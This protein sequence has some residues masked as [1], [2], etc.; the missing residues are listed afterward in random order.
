MAAPV[1]SI[2]S[3]SSY[4]SVGSHS[5]AD[6]LVA[7][8]VGA[9]IVILP[10]RVLDLVDYSSSSDSNP[11]EDSLLV[12]PEL[13]LV[14]SFLCSN[15]SEADNSSSD[16]SLD[17]SSGSSSDSFS[18]LSLVHSLGCDASGQSHSGPSTRVA[19]PRSLDLSL[20][21]AGPSR[22]RCR[23]PATLVPSST[24]ISR[25][26]APAL[27]D[28]PPRKR[29][30]DSYSSKVGEEEHMEIGTADL[31]TVTDLG[32]SDGVGAHIKDG[33]DIGVE[34]VTSD[35]RGDEQ[36]F[37][38]EASAR[39][40]MEI[41]VDPLATGGISN[42]TGG[43]APDLEGTLYDI[44]HYMYEVPLDRITGTMTNTCSG[45]TS[46]VIEEMINR[47][48]TEALETREA[49][50]NIGL[51]NG[52]DEGG[53]GNGNGNENRGRNGNGNHNEND[54]DARPVV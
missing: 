5:P 38:A 30:R 15:D 1:I 9:V 50:K 48:V 13:P 8:E 40:T 4:E 20:P 39:G 28:L 41:V 12:A 17:I 34:V 16:S 27:T 33:I 3:D 29:F 37:E 51:W 11:S 45:M 47:R 25:S 18:D 10:T 35:I 14:S 36:E 46:A 44:A 19:S 54:R 42:P 6:P 53:K 32:I 2:S 43:D 52:N 22:K 49:N 26:I 24:P 31:E 7:P 21:S 23:S